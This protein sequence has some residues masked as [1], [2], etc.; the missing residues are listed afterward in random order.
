[1]EECIERILISEEE[2]QQKV[3]ELGWR[4]TQ[5][6]REKEIR[7]VG[8]LR[9]AFIFMADLVRHIKVPLSVD[10]MSISSYGEESESNG[11]VRILK[12][13]DKPITHKHVLIVEDIVDTGL[14]L[15]HL[16]EVLATREP[17]SLKVCA[18][19]SKEERRLVKDLE[20]DYV[21]FH[22]P[23]QFVVGYGLDFA[24]RYRNYPFIFVLKP[25]YYRESA[26]G[27]E[28]EKKDR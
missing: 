3:R 24:E 26:F 11:I 27:R 17:A 12:D 4:I 18:L 5:D 20:I 23:N 28:K 8:I 25:E 15:K 22:V 13:L 9:G 14:T 10:F 7:V 16:K 1:M 2:L 6:Y 19:L 21:G